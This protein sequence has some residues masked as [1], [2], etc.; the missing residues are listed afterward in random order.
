ML[1][2]SRSALSEVA[3]L[4][5]SRRSDAGFAG[6][7]ADL[8]A[9]CDLLGREKA[10]RQALSDA[11]R[12]Q[13]TRGEIA[14]QLFSG[15]VSPLATEVLIATV[16]QRWS[17]PDDLVTGLRILGDRAA[18]MVAA[19]GGSLD[20]TEDQ[21]FR[22]GRI[23]SGSASLQAALTDPAISN[24]AKSGII[25]DLVAGKVTETTALVVG[26]AL[27]HLE[28]RRVEQAV[29]ELVELAAEQRQ[30]VVALIK[31]ARPL[32]DDLKQRMAAAL[33]RLTGRGVGVNIV[34]DPSVIGGAHVTIAGEVIDG[35]IATRLADARRLMVG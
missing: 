15:R 5:E 18:F 34:V 26:F 33:G 35:T 7:A 22:L 3:D 9:A 31:V 30:R 1:S 19:D 29:D 27:S 17:S 24:S 4:L 23:V 28:G 25:A 6:V 8:Y 14:E 21:I 13:R 32:D 10:L 2:A 20:A 11:G 12:P 16:R